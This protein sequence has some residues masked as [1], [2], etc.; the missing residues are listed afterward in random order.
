MGKKREKDI[1]DGSRQNADF[2][3]ARR[4]EQKRCKEDFVLR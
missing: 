1:N 3:F 2:G 4:F